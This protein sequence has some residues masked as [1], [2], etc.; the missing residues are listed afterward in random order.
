MDRIRQLITTQDIARV[1][2]KSQYVVYCKVVRDTYC[3]DVFQHVVHQLFGAREVSENLIEKMCKH[4]VEFTFHSRSQCKWNK[5]KSL[6]TDR[7]FDKGK[8]LGRCELLK[9]WSTGGNDSKKERQQ[10]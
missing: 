10:E 8:K 4:N 5:F 9:V 1:G 2:S 6:R 7:V 3:K